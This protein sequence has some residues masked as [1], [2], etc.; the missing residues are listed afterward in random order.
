MMTKP[1]IL[2][3]F[4]ERYPEASIDAEDQPATGIHWLVAWFRHP[5]ENIQEDV[6]AYNHAERYQLLYRKHI[7]IWLEGDSLSELFDEIDQLR[8]RFSA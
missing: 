1:Q 5:G 3:A 7:N 4:R 2:R 8:S 6:A